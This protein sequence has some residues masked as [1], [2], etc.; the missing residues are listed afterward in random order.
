MPDHGNRVHEG[1]AERC[2]STAER[3]PLPT[4]EIKQQMTARYRNVQNHPN[5]F[6]FVQF[7]DNK[8]SLQCFRVSWYPAKNKAMTVI[9]LLI[10][11]NNIPASDCMAN[12]SCLHGLVF[13]S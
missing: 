10:T 6:L 11:D 9:F 7:K 12:R 2:L 13:L 4:I 1:F 3:K 8:F 5:M